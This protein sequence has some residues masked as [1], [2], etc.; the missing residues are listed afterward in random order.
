MVRPPNVPRFVCRKLRGQTTIL[1]AFA[2][3]AQKNNAQQ[4]FA[5]H[6]QSTG[7]QEQMPAFADHGQSTGD[8]KQMPPVKHDHSVTQTFPRFDVNR[9]ESLLKFQ[10]WL[11]GIEGKHRT[12]SAARN[13]AIDV[14]KFL[15]HCTSEKTPDWKYLLQK[16]QVL[17]FLAKVEKVGCGPEGR[18]TKLDNL[19]TALRYLRLS[20][21]EQC[22]EL[23]GQA[24][25]MDET[26]ASFKR[27][28]CK[29]KYKRVEQRLEELSETPLDVEEVMQV[30][31]NPVMWREFQEVIDK[32][33]S[34]EE[35]EPRQLELC[36]TA[37]ATLLL[38]KSWQRPRAVCNLTVAEYKNAR[39]VLGE[40][41]GGTDVFV[42]SAREHKTGIKGPARLMLTND[43]VPKLSLSAADAAKY[44]KLKDVIPTRYDINGNSLHVCRTLHQS[45]LRTAQPSK[46][47]GRP[48]C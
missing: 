18:I 37:I 4:A 28:L 5:G 36:T 47:F 31:D 38:F 6:G 30:V 21:P 22:P 14:S 29:F 10:G 33:T 13:I 11:R 32:I 9:E 39:L 15:C 7:N 41:P 43:D 2:D 24:R 20:D 48:S 42:M 1:Q 26:I 45:G 3:Q 44:A 34:E 17:S 46:P 16:E 12:A 27:T 25:R 40:G 19:N 23:E 8:Q 35:V